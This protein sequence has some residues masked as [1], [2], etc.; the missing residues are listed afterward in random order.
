MPSEENMIDEVS[1]MEPEVFLGY[2]RRLE[3][4]NGFEANV[5]RLPWWLGECEQVEHLN[6]VVLQHEKL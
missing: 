5:M 6:T 4:L 3:E 1:R 2:K